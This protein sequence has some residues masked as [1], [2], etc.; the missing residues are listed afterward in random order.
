MPDILRVTCEFQTPCGHHNLTWNNG[1]TTYL[2]KWKYP[3][4]DRKLPI[5][6]DLWTRRAAVNKTS[7]RSKWIINPLSMF[8]E[9]N[10][11]L[12]FIMLD[13]NVKTKY[14]IHNK[15]KCNSIIIDCY[16]EIYQTL[17]YIVFYVWNQINVVIFFHLFHKRMSMKSFWFRT[18]LYYK[19][20]TLHGF[21]FYPLG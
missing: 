1:R 21:V 17:L 13:S 6:E 19:V 5:K 4:T 11:D 3:H 2:T 18:I 9:C 8:S 14:I 12:R 20:H 16:R 10:L 7:T 15:L